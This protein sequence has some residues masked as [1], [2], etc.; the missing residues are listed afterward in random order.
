MRL[1]VPA[2]K[3][4]RGVAGM[5]KKYVSKFA[6]DILPSVAATIIGAYIVNHYIVSK[7]AANAPAAVALSAVDPKKADTK[8]DAKSDAKPS[9]TS[10]DVANIPEPGV[11]AKGISEKAVIEKSAIEKPAEKAADKAEKSADKPAETASIPVGTR[12]HQPAPREKPIAKAVPAPVQPAAPVSAPVVAAPVTVLVPPVQATIVP[13]ER[14]DANDLARAAIE[15]LRGANDGS[16]RAQ[17]AARI[18]DVPRV[19]DAPRVQE[20]SRVVSASPVRPL[21]PPIM[22]STPTAQTFD[23][24]A[25]SSQMRSPYAARIDDP[26]RPTPPADIP[27]AAPS[28]PPLDLH[29]EAEEPSRRGH[30]TVAEDVLSAAKS[31][32]HAVLPKKLSD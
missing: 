15:R 29:A 32:F 2:S 5:L 27:V 11:K 4:A 8:S 23:S 21:P 28:S 14:R 17:E 20:P 31:V 16:P 24:S 12:R 26:H 30:T 1:K 6:M 25:G 18:P 13:E 9:E 7:P 22:V 10:A 19:P 3:P